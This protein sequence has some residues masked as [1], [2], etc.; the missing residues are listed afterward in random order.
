MLHL[1]LRVTYGW[2]LVLAKFR[3]LP[4][5]YLLCSDGPD[6]LHW[7]SRLKSTRTVIFLVNIIKAYKAGKTYREIPFIRKT[8][9]PEKC[10]SFWVQKAF[11]RLKRKNS[12]NHCHSGRY[13]C[14]REDY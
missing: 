7:K 10:T 9:Y 2:R 6:I 8:V 4:L 12:H 13:Y 1:R 14:Y 11:S 5:S 3:C